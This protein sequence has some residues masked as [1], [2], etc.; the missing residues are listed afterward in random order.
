MTV[1]CRSP[2]VADSLLL[3][4]FLNPISYINYQGKDSRLT[5]MLQNSE[6]GYLF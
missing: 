2:V 5:K 3:L 6:S 1:I 4:S